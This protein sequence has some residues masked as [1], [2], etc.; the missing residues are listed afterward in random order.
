MSI[1]LDNAATT[2]LRA[3]VVAA[4]SPFWLD[5]FHNPSGIYKGSR[6]AKAAMEQ[7]RE[8]IAHAICADAKGIYF[9]GSGTESI[10][11]AIKGIAGA[12]PHKK[13]II[14]SNIE[15]PA[16]YE[17]CEYLEKFGYQITYL[18]VDGDGIVC[19]DSLKSAIRPDTLMA[20]IMFANNEIGTIQPIA[21]IGQICRENGIYFHTDAV[22]AFGR[23]FIDVNKMNIDLLSV[24][25]HKLHGPKGVGALY[26]RPGIKL[27]NL[28]HGGGQERKRRAGTE[29]VPGIVGFGEAA[30]LA[31]QEIEFEPARQAELRDFYINQVLER[32]PHAR[33]NGHKTRRLCGIANISFDF[34]EGESILLMLD[35]RGFAASSGSACT[36]G[37]LDPSHVLLALGLDHEQ[38]HGS[39]RVS[40][41]RETTEADLAA[42]V[43]EL[44]IIVNRLREMSPLYEDFLK[45]GNGK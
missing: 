24:S 22:Q 26:V 17:V 36:S 43:N 45:G 28:I 1:Y 8:H 12:N 34:I 40:I 23:E 39:L 18:D 37:S 10:N 38:A 2:P 13:H 3:E 44:E 42:L 29:N 6:G 31:Y 4:M 25:A 16:V 15:H 41:G 33:L 19:A 9:T 20:S 35:M 30:R 5:N 27:D 32:I 14:I 11:W 21:E 7:A